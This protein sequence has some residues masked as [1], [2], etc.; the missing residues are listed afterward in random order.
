MM[1]YFMLCVLCFFLKNMTAQT[2]PNPIM[3]CTQVPQP[4][5]F[6]S[7]MATFGNHAGSLYAA[8][9][10]GDLYIR[11]TDGTL[12]NLTQAAGYG[13]TGQQGATAIAVRDPSVYWDG[14][15]AIFSMV[16]GAATARYQVATYYWQLYEITGIGQGQ[17]PVI[18][19]VP[20][21]PTTYN[22]VQPIYGTDDRIIFTSDRPRG[23]AAH[24]YP[25]LD[26]YESAAIVSGLWR[27]D[28]KACSQ[29]AGLEMLT[30]SP[31]GDFTP[32]IDQAGRVIFT[33]WDHLK[34]DQQAD[35]DIMS[36][37]GYGTFNYADETAAAA[38][39]ANSPEIEIFPEPRP[40][41][42]DLLAL[43]QWANTNPQDLNIFN[44]WMMTEDGTELEILNH[45]GLHEM[46]SYI[47]PNFTNDPNLHDYYTP[48]SPTPIT[49][50]FHIKESLTTA[51]LYYGTEAIEFGT[52]ASGMIVT[53][54]AP[55]G[56]H[57]EQI[58]FT[59]ITHPNTRSP[60]STPTV[61]HSGMYRN[62]TPLTNGQ[63]LVV[64][65]PE[66]DF[67]TNIGT[68]A[69]P[70]S[71]YAYRLRLLESAGNGYQKAGAATLTGAGI[72]K[73]V[74]WWS[75]DEA[76]SYSGVLW[77]TYPVEVY[78][79][80]R[81]ATT[82][83][84]KETLP[85]IEQ[86]LFTAANVNLK[87][88]RKFLKRNNI[89]LLVTRDVTSR[90]DAD[91]QQPYNLK[92]AGSAHQTV[93]PSKPGT[94]YDVKYLQYLQADQLRGMGG[95]VSP[96]AGR[97]PIAQLLHDPNAVAYNPT[98]TGATGSVNVH[99][100]GSVAA[101][102]PANRAVT[103]QLTD[104][105]N[106]G[107]VRERLWL[108]AVPGEIR[109]CTSCHG[110]STLNQAGLTSPTNAPQALTTLLNW[111]KAID[112]DNDGVKDLYDAYPTDATKSVAEPVN[113]QFIANLTNWANQNPDND[114]A[115]WTTANTSTFATAAV[116]NNH[117]GADN[118][119]K[120]DRLRRFVNL[121]N[122]DY[123]KLSFDV[124]YARYDAS[125][126]DRLKV[127]AVNCNGTTDLV[128]DKQ[129]NALATAPDQTTTFTPADATQWRKESINLSA[130]VGKTIELVFEDVGG[131][132]NRLFLDNILVQE[133]DIAVPLELT[134]FSG[135]QVDDANKLEW[136]TVNEQNVRHFVVEKSS[137]ALDKFQNIG[138]VKAKGSAGT[139][140]YYSL[141]DAEPSL[142]NYY[143][144]KMTDN[145]GQ[146]K[147]SK[148]IALANNQSNK[149]GVELYPNPVTNVLNIALKNK[150]YRIA[151]ARLSDITG[152]IL[153]SQ[154]KNDNTSNGLPFVLDMSAFQS[155][156]Y[157]VV[158]TIDGVS[159]LHKVI[160]SR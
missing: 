137:D 30:H 125:K 95:T 133:L 21:Q 63:V 156:V 58:A 89:A 151:T 114:A 55:P 65:A 29:S 28:P 73:N 127:Y 81:P 61:N 52:H 147:Y 20:N 77:E 22:N 138:E 121:T 33:R 48:P 1:R 160:V 96:R 45:L 158:V 50:M 145:D 12:K 150:N 128:Y 76:R 112:R 56:M 155:G 90:D 97:R 54:N 144:L 9:R 67:D 14:T 71:K 59:Y 19:L 85:S 79:R 53:V 107:I 51:G 3:F 98:T 120:M 141:F 105:N 49:A 122:M 142:L 46:K 69:A 7:L 66:T 32:T 132:G 130:Y 119:G 103:W 136:Q 131:W 123:A 78:A 26:E 70:L 18:T 10:G 75:P 111:V 93:N 154:S 104:A 146:F 31:S 118:T 135:K 87:D 134:Q 16:I 2:L 129:G 157:T 110:E 100:D 13:Q 140:Q 8:P 143:R 86:G 153:I 25:Q 68:S 117:A 62:P 37:A 124:A 15:K 35:A 74:T 108:S 159:S 113:E 83:L 116:I 84:N 109:S 44:P 126:F 11:Y 40:S 139:P 149:G 57:P 99:P 47:L 4:S 106:K 88:F 23:G 41:R 43:P 39:S 17:T 102:V 64:H 24:L 34:R 82:T 5:D 91:Q 38:R 92:V 6:A 152:K 115:A 36:N 148:T 42:T 80:T 72:T 60:S 27:L 94:I 101:I